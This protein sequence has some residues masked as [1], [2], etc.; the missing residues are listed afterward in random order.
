MQCV[1]IKNVV[2]EIVA[3]QF[4]L[5]LCEFLQPL[6]YMAIDSTGWQSQPDTLLREM[7]KPFPPAWELYQQAE[8]LALNWV[9]KGLQISSAYMNPPFKGQTRYD[10]QKREIQIF[11]N[12]ALNTSMAVGTLIHELATVLFLKKNVKLWRQ[13]EAGRLNRD[14]FASKLENLE[15]QAAMIHSSVISQLKKTEPASWNSVPDGYSTLKE[16]CQIQGALGHT[17]CY[18]QLYDQNFAS[19]AAH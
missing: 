19:K 2:T 4:P 6:G 18:R 5:S 12:S 3:L 15:A 17:E 13:A 8:K 16:Y 1:G 14:T 7:I 11:I 9:G 10:P